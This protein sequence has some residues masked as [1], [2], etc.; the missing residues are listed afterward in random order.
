LAR[1]ALDDTHTVATLLLSPTRDRLLSVVVPADD[2]TTVRL[3]A[4]V[5]GAF[6]TTA[7]L[8]A[9]DTPPKLRL[10]VDVSLRMLDV[11]TADTPDS[12]PPD[13]LPR[14]AD[15]DA[16]TD[17]VAPVSPVR[18]RTVPTA[19]DDDASSVTLVDPVVAVFLAIALLTLTEPYDK[20]AVAL[21]RD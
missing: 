18:T 6:R 4:P 15:D 16:H 5:V 14:T 20:A 19:A 11:A 7:L 10:I 3:V 9:S 13:T 21:D 8:S 2:T 17:A 12:Y 1:T